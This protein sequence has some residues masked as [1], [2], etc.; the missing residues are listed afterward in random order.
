MAEPAGAGL[1]AVRHCHDI[2][3]LDEPE[4]RSNGYMRDG[5]DS[6]PDPRDPRALDDELAAAIGRLQQARAEVGTLMRRYGRPTVTASAEGQS[7]RQNVSSA[8]ISPSTR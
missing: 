2:G 8:G 4:R 3:L 6:G 1:G 7:A 5:P